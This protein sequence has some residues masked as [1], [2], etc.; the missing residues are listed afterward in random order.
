M[1][2]HHFLLCNPAKEHR[3]PADY[4]VT[5]SR[6]K[7]QA[8]SLQPEPLVCSQA[9]PRTRCVTLDKSSGPLCLNFVLYNGVN[10]ITYFIGLL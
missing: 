9:L 2:T 3:M 5:C 7:G 6:V 4:K 8:E 10:S 1:R